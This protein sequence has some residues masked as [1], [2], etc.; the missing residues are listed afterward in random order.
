MAPDR[1]LFGIGGL[2][3]G[4][5]VGF[6]FAN[7]INRTASESQVAGSSTTS[8]AP[9]NLNLPPDHQPLGTN[10]GQPQQG[11]ALPQVTEAI[12]RA[13]QQPNSFEAQMTAGDLYYQIQRFAD[14]A[15]FYE[16]ANQIKPGEVEPMI[17]LG[18]AYF[19]AEQYEPAEKWY[20]EALKKTPNDTSVR[21]DLGLT[22][23]LRS[24]REIEKAVKEFQAVLA[25][26]P[27]K[28]I[29]LQN[30]ALAYRESGNTANLDK[31]LEKL[32]KIN[33]NN[34]VVTRSGV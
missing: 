20:L 25:I 4:I 3:I 26:E 7:S 32:K 6:M 5:I 24:P 34:P 18:N 9:A 8:D 17:K 31:T 2:L 15:K 19:D 21:T 29:T 27:D 33:P 28:E 13:K 16:K 14:A 11:G 10:G 1:L 22:Y 12:E 23:Y 30:L